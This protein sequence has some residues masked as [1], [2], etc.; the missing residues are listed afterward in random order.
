R[1]AGKAPGNGSNGF[2]QTLWVFFLFL[3]RAAETRC[4]CCQGAACP[5]VLAE[6]GPRA[7]PPGRV[8]WR[9][10]LALAHRPA[11]AERRRR[12]SAN[13]AR[14]AAGANLRYRRSPVVAASSHEECRTR[15]P[16]LTHPCRKRR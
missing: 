1:D 10:A 5:R 12:H 16:A 6:R 13:T 8:W 2:A 9:F 15:I 14:S 11:P 7:T 4:S 3:E